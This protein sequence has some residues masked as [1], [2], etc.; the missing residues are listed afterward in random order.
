MISIF[1]ST[2]FI[3][4]RFCEMYPDEV[5][6][7]PR[8]SFAGKLQDQLYLISTTHNYNVLSKDVRVNLYHLSKVLSTI[9]YFRTFNFVSSWFVYGSDLKLPAKETDKCKPQ[10]NYSFTKYMAEQMVIMYCRRELIPYRI[11]RLANVFGKDDKYS[12]KKNALQYLVNELRHD[13]D[14]ELYYGG[15]FIRDYIHVDEVCRLLHDGME[16]LPLNDVYNI[17]TGVPIRF[18]DLISLAKGWLGSKS[19]IT[20]VEPSEFHKK[21]Q[22]KDFYMDVSKITK[23]GLA[24]ERYAFVLNNFKDVVLDENV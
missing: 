21:V 1:G 3:G 6:R 22:I 13:R 7:V 16:K 10:G 15:E 14:I 12:K 23:Y 20:S 4:G 8:D 19:K 11:F 9:N 24:P 18:I 5:Y 2:G 17:G